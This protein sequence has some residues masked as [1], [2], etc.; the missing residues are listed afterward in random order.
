MKAAVLTA[1]DQPLAIQALPDPEPGPGEAVIDMA[2]AGVASYTA[3]V[4]SG[5]RNYMLELPIVPGPGGVGR[6]RSVGPDATRLKPGDWV[7]CDS[8]IRSRDD[9]LTPD[10]ILLGWTA[11]TPAALPLHRHFHNGAFAQQM[12]VPLETLSP[13]GEIDA[14]EAGRWTVLG[15]LLVPFG[16]LLAGDLK[17]GE[18]LLV[19]GATGGFGGAGVV[20]ALAMGAGRVVAA[21]R[22]L[23]ALQRLADR[24]GPRV[25][26]APMTGDS[27]ADQARLREAAQGPVDM[28]LDFLPREATAA[29]ALTAITAVRPGG[30]V[31]LMGGLRGP[32]G[33]LGVNYNW[34]MHN[35]VTLKGQW[36][37]GR[38]AMP[39]MVQ[40]VRAG[41]VD[42][43]AF[44]LTE[45][46]LT[47]ANEAVAYAAEVGGALQRV[48]R[49]P[50][51]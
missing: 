10:S 25:V 34:L 47:Q 45:F 50:D 24:L 3:G 30:R 8:T 9:V 49:R 18:T 6:V 12:R 35:N 21:G 26:P 41:L 31:V 14:A 13:L 19:S 32:N 43:D 11:R 44:D 15:S 38:E 51:R 27:Q 29:Q 4:L 42:L 2:A 17:A 37:Y 23:G 5:A 1:L 7:Y 28:V 39:R 20:A 16:G 36:M 33:D 22:N 48:A 40:M 46:P